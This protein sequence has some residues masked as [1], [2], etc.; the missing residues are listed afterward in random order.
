[1][2]ADDI[3]VVL[4]N[5]TRYS[6]K[7]CGFLI[8]GAP[9]VGVT[10]LDYADMI[11]DALVH[12]ANRD[13]APL[14]STSGKYV[15][16]VCKITMLADVFRKKFLPQHAALSLAVGG[17]ATIS[18]HRFPIIVNFREGLAPPDVDILSGCRV[19][20]VSDTYAEGADVKLTEVT[21][22]VLSITRNGIALFDRSR[23]LP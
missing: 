14:G 1:M 9:Y 22:R 7:S 10:A 16:D 19:L 6:Q 5:R 21:V 13:G 4:L 11:E 20:G 2:P 18:A 17:I 23:S 3:E 8:G 12:G 15:P